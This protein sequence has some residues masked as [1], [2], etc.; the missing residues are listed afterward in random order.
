MKLKPLNPEQLAWV[1]DDL[2]LEAFPPAELKPLSAM[3]DMEQ[4]GLYLPYGFFDG[5]DIIGAC[6]LWLGEAGVALIDHLCVSP[7]RRNEGLGETILAQI[8]QL[9]PSWVFI[10]ESEYPPLAPEPDLAER[11]LGFYRRNQAKTADFR[12][13]VFG[14]SY[15][16][17][18]W[19]AELTMAQYAYIYQRSFAPEKYAKYVIIPYTSTAPAP[20]VDWEQ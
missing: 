20:K 3:V 6:F 1:Y 16:I 17:F 13:R 7:K 11:R 5:Q 12:T 19:G 4:R 18:Y 8:Q 2:L 10:A 14:V 15:T 9:Y